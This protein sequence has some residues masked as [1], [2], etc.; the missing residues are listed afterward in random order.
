MRVVVVFCYSNQFRA[1]FE[2]KSKLIIFLVLESVCYVRFVFWQ[3]NET[4]NMCLLITHCLSLRKSQMI[5]FVTKSSCIMS[6]WDHSNLKRNEHVFILQHI[7][8]IICSY[9]RFI[10]PRLFTLW[11]SSSWPVVKHVQVDWNKEKTVQSDYLNN[12]Y[13][14]KQKHALLAH[15]DPFIVLFGIIHLL[16][17]S[18]PRRRMLIFRTNNKPKDAIFDIIFIFRLNN[19]SLYLYCFGIHYLPS[20]TKKNRTPYKT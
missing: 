15:T 14:Y 11:D 2:A 1:I 5:Y 18:L 4:Y 17:Q 16:R 6:Q 12:W 7:E 19:E 20:T 13:P 8:I 10:L 9:L 3:I